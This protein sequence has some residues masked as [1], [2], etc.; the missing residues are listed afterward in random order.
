MPAILPELQLPANTQ[1]RAPTETE[2]KLAKGIALVALGTSYR[3]AADEVGCSSSVLFRHA[4]EHLVVHRA[5]GMPDREG[6]AHLIAEVFYE[7]LAQLREAL[8]LG[9]IDQKQLPY[10]AGVLGDKLEKI[11]YKNVESNCSEDWLAA[12]SDR[13]SPD[14]TLEL[15]VS[16]PPKPISVTATPI[17]SHPC[18]TDKG[19][20]PDPKE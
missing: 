4:K 14:Q 8:L 10:V 15:K 7:V 16:T 12:I 13:L 5:P 2:L 1:Q 18:G 17:D 20:S 9:K 3:K 11:A 6:V 19:T